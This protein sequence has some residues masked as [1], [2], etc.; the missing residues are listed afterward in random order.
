MFNQIFHEKKKVP[1]PFKT[2]IVTPLLKKSKGPT[3]LDNYRGITVTPILVKLFETVLL[4]RIA[5]NFE[6]SPLQFGFTQELSPVMSALIVSEARAEARITCNKNAP[7]FLMT[8]D[9]QK[10]F[11]VVNHVTLLDNLYETGIHPSLWTNFQIPIFR[12]ILKSKMDW[13]I[14]RKLYHSTRGQAGSN[15][16][17]F[18]LQNLS[19]SVPRRT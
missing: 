18:P 2:G 3:I 10:A 19:E 9:S 13:R 1:E 6:Q 16:V 12:I 17:P 11:V 15:P 7:L 4:P 8:L 14:E 5:K